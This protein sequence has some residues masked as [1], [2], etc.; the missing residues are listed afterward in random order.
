MGF[1]GS[2]QRT[3]AFFAAA[4]AI[5]LVLAG[6]PQPGGDGDGLAAFKL[7]SV[8]PLTGDL[9]PFG[10][11]AE[12]AVQL[13]VKKVNENGGVNDQDVI[14]ISEDSETSQQAAPQA[15]S[16]LVNVEGIHGLVGAM[17]SGISL[18]FID[19]IAQAGIPMISP[20][21]TAPT[22]STTYGTQGGDNGWYF[23]T[24]PADTLQGKVMTQLVIDSGYS[25]TAILAINND[26][27]V[28]FGDIFQQEYETD[29][30]AAAGGR[31]I[32]DYVKYDPE[33]T[34]FGSTVDDVVGANEPAEDPEAVVV[35]GYPDTVTAIM[36]N[37]FEKGYAGPNG[38]V[39]WF[40][41]EGLKDESGFVD[42]VNKTD[43]GEYILA[44]YRGTTPEF[45][46]GQE[47]ATDF[48]NEYG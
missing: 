18:S 13:A 45:D 25:K 8:L 26:Y 23:R 38:S 36:T 1:E 7:G 21:N 31:D 48:Q 11:S 4:I 19:Q 6:C 12:K 24:V 17:G 20:S 5:A 15:V 47:F 10:P 40:F 3:T 32:T 2:G 22:F 28:G 46:I 42:E 37:A 9:S 41:S 43:D 34:T 44:G 33:A 30:P 27:G 16:R 39:D 14:H 29:D 35:I